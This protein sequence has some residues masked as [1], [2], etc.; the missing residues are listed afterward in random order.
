MNGK[1]DT[2]YDLADLS[3]RVVQYCSEPFSVPTCGLELR[4]KVVF[5]VAFLK[6]V[7]D[8]CWPMSNIGTCSMFDQTGTGSAYRNAHAGTAK[9][10]HPNY[11]NPLAPVS[12]QKRGS[13]LFVPNI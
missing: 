5:V 11:E 6:N 7:S 1:L 10:G 2:L 13:G 9:R 3:R 12:A 8:A 4:A